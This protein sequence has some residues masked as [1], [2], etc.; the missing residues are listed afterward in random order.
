MMA[1]AQPCKTT[2][3]VR[4]LLEFNDKGQVKNTMQNVYL[5]FTCDPALREAIAHNILTGRIDICRPVWWERTTSAMN[6]T[7]FNYLIPVGQTASFPLPAI[8]AAMY[9]ISISAFITN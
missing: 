3:E 1:A 6:D 9:M 8:G 7:D 2:E 4:A 5:V